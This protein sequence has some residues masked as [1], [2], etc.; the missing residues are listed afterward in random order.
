MLNNVDQCWTM[1]IDQ[2]DSSQV[3][4]DVIET[5]INKDLDE[6]QG[7]TTGYT[8]LM[9]D[10]E[11][12]ANVALVKPTEAFNKGTPTEALNAETLNP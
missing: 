6:E 11:D 12:V 3:D 4:L 10:L 5:T 1:L 2:T 7:G 9:D 8:N